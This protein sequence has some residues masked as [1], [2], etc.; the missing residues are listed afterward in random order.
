MSNSDELWL[1]NTHDKEVTIPLMEMSPPRLQ[2]FK[3]GRPVPLPRAIAMKYMN[4]WQTIK[5]IAD[6]APY[7]T[8]NKFHQ[9]VIRDSGLGDLLLLEPSLRTLAEAG[10]GVTLMS[11]FI[12]LFKY[13]PGIEGL[14]GPMKTIQDIAYDPKKFDQVMDLRWASEKHDRRGDVHRSDIYSLVL[15]VRPTQK[16][17]RLYWDLGKPAFKREKGLRYVGFEL[18]AQDTYRRYPRARAMALV[19]YF[20]NQ[21]PNIRAVLIGHRPYLAMKHKQIIDLQGKTSIEE[22]VNTIA[23]LDALVAVDSGLLHVGL[24]LHVPTVCFFGKM[25]ADLRVRYYTGPR[26][27]V[28]TSAS[29]SPCSD[30]TDVGCLHGN[31]MEDWDY[32]KP[33]C[34][35]A[36]CTDI[37]PKDFYDAYK[38]LPQAGKPVVYSPEEKLGK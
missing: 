21:D 7:L 1:V 27:I 9:L 10:K 14:I 24:T 15:G 17:P 11:K 18:D 19:N 6:P 12:D 25:T 35:M 29:C 34:F 4:Q 26:E 28:K 23:G 5:V 36:P 38:R 32:T 3:P 33:G 8:E 37:P 22:A 2:T 20:V 16:E 31:A 13:H 30:R